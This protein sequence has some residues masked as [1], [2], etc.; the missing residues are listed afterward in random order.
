MTDRRPSTPPSAPGADEPAATAAAP[1]SPAPDRDTRRRF[2]D[3][4]ASLSGVGLAIAAGYPAFRFVTPLPQEHDSAGSL[5]LG[6]AS[7]FPLDSSRTVRF[8][9]EPVVVVRDKQG[10]FHAL[11][12]LCPHL[13]C[14]VAYQPG[15]GVVTCG[16][17]QGSFAL[18]G[19]NIAG[20]PPRPLK[21]F[22]IG[23]VGDEVILGAAS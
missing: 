1:A 2:L 10:A 20:P 7:A 8:G 13:Q 6:A 16:C 12:A 18:S 17:H 5:S 22:P 15:A 11:S 19:K 21:T 3:R 23:L 4:A 9:G 14:I